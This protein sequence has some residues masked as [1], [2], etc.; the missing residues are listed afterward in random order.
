MGHFHVPPISAGAGNGFRPIHT[1][2]LCSRPDAP[3]VLDLIEEFSPHWGGTCMVGVRIN[4]WPFSGPWMRHAG[5]SRQT[6]GFV[7]P[8]GSFQD[9]WQV[10]TFVL[11]WMRECGQVHVTELISELLLFFQRRSCCDL[12]CMSSV[13]CVQLFHWSLLFLWLHVA[14]RWD[15]RH[16]L[17]CCMNNSETVFEH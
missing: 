15:M 2:L 11:T 16:V 5:T 12:L 7:T 8:E 13:R 3:A 9:V 17:W 10:R 4:T 1:L 14:P 6:R